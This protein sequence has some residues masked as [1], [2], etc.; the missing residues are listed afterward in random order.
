MASAIILLP[1]YINF[2]PTSVYGALSLYLAFSLFVQILVVYSFDT[3]IYIHYHDYKND[4]KTL[5]AFVSSA[6]LM[7]LMIGVGGGVILTL[8][9]DVLFDLIF[10]DARISFYPFGLMAVAIGIF[11]GLFKVY[12]SLLQSREKPV[13]FLRSNLF[14]F[15]LI[16]G[17]TILGLYVYPETLIGPIGGRVLA[18]T[19]GTAWVLYRVHSEF[20]F[21]FNFPLLKSTFGFNHYSFIYQLQQWFINN[22]DRF[23]MLFA[24]LS[25]TSIGIYDFAIKCLVVIEVLMSGLHNSFYPKVVSAITA[26]AEKRSTVEINRYYHGLIASVM[27]MIV[28]SIFALPFVLELIDTK[29]RYLDAVQY[30]PYIAVIYILR[31][32]RTYFA[33]PYGVLKYTKPL[34]VIYAVVT[35]LKIG[36]M[37]VLVKKFEVYGLVA[38]SLISVS[39]EIVILKYWLAGKFKFEFNVFKIVIAPLGLLLTIVLLEILFSEVLSWRLH[40]FYIVV[41]GALLGWGYRNELKALEIMK[42]IKRS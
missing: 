23:I 10:H 38:A 20:G 11:Q 39:L 13:L 41:T 27:L 8:L 18:G 16:C 29:Q 33:S 42:M 3:S 28:F 34:P 15:S 6:F 32:L 36:L 26:Q 35:L 40:I 5:S 31:S 22:S 25:L 17:L 1:F 9:G 30:F 12:S 24:G 2:L 37:I 14:L 19:L 7:M 21:Q 4:F